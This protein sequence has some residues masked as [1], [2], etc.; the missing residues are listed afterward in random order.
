MMAR[1]DVIGVANL[2]VSTATLTAIGAAVWG[3]TRK[4]KPQK[5]SEIE[6]PPA[7]APAGLRLI[8]GGS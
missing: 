2:I 1:A 8:K 6:H 3:V 5:R 4:V 7:T